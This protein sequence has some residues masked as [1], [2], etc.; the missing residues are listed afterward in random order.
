MPKERLAD[1]TMVAYHSWAVSVHRLAAVD[2]ATG[3]VITTGAAPWPFM[4]WGARQRYHVENFK[5]AL[6][7]P[8]EWFLDRDGTLFYK[9]L[10]GEDMAKAEVVAPRG[11]GPAANHRRPGRPA[12]SSSTSRSAGW[13]SATRPYML[14]PEGHGDGQA[15]VGVPAAVTVDGARGVAIEDCEIGTWAATRVWFRR[16]CRECRLVKSY[17]HDMGAGGVRIG[18]GWENDHPKPAEQT[19][20]VTVDNN[21]IRSGGHLFRGA[22]GVWIGHSPYNTVTHNDMADFYYT[23]ISVGWRGATPRAWPITTRSTSTTS[24]TSAGAC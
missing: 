24:T 7:E 12:S 9:P 23:G 6:D 18:Q 1:V 19:S 21:I 15:A 22:V 17:V 16:G 11:R 14:P 20:H 5:A 3:T 4:R 10:P 2:R 13:P 8:G